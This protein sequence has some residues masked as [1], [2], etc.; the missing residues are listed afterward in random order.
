MHVAE[1]RK[2]DAGRHHLKVHRMVMHLRIAADVSAL[3]LAHFWI[4]GSISIVLDKL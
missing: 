3:A 1:E 2:S 4:V